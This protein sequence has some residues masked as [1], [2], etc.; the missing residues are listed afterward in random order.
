MLLRLLTIILALAMASMACG[1]QMDLPQMPTAGPAVTEEVSVPVP[2]GSGT[3][4]LT[5][6]FGAGSCT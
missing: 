3:P 4:M 1:F 2:E 5:L 6:G